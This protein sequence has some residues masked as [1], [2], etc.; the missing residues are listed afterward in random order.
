M[1][2]LWRIYSPC[3]FACLSSANE[4]KPHV[5]P[6]VFPSSPISDVSIYQLSPRDRN[7]SKCISF[8]RKSIRE[9][10]HIASMWYFLIRWWW[11]SASRPKSVMR[12]I[13]IWKMS[14]IT[15]NGKN[16]TSEESTWGYVLYTLLFSLYTYEY[17]L[18]VKTKSD[19]VGN[20]SHRPFIT[21][22]VQHAHAR[23]YAH[24]LV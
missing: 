12:C 9:Y 17:M 16:A 10:T 6:F 1:E 24:I 4:T 14:T 19:I 2:S 18:S 11:Q 13:E 21:R 3:V 15:T 22:T 7:S 20:P 23:I 8:S 5:T